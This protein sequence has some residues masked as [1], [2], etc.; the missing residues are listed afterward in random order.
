M[1]LIIFERVYISLKSV[2]WYP[3]SNTPDFSK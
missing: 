3:L 2:K 1:H